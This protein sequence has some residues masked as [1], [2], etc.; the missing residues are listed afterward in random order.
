MR[1]TVPERVVTGFFF[2]PNISKSGLFIRS[3][4]QFSE[5]NFSIIGMAL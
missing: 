2:N 1:V 4:N 3:F 5:I